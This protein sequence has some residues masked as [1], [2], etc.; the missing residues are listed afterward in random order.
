MIQACIEHNL[1]TTKVT[2][3]DKRPGIVKSIQKKLERLGMKKAEDSKRFKQSYSS[4]RHLTARV[5]IEVEQGVKAAAIKIAEPSQLR[6]NGLVFRMSDASF[7]YK[8]S[9]M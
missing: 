7:K 2:E 5:Q 6:Y 1:Q 8:K 9:T 4:G 3:G